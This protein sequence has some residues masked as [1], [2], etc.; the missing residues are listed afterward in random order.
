MVQA[1]TRKVTQ[2]GQ[3]LTTARIRSASQAWLI[4]STADRPRPLMQGRR[5]AAQRAEVT[6]HDEQ[7]DAMTR[8]APS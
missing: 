5:K 6:G 8:S 1:I 2:D 7:P 3:E 4:E